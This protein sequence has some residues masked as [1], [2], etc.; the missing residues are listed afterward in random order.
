MVVVVVAIIENR[1]SGTKWAFAVAGGAAAAAV[2]MVCACL[3][4]SLRM[5]SWEPPPPPPTPPMTLDFSICKLFPREFKTAVQRLW[6]TACLL[7]IPNSERPE[8]ACCVGSAVLKL[9]LFLMR[10]LP[11]ICR[12]C[13]VK[14]V[15]RIP[16]Q[17]AMLFA[18]LG[19]GTTV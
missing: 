15:E 16:F 12:Q 14:R 7:R 1:F 11:K 18:E 5:E 13:V 17:R 4:C 10:K 8:P 3:W 19:W 6:S 2:L 9:N